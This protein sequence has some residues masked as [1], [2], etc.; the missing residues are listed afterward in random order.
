MEGVRRE[1]AS[2]YMADGSR[3]MAEVSSLLGFSAPSGFSRWYRQQ[4][5]TTASGRGVRSP[6]RAG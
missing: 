3:S 2:R 4:F 5:G 6:R 1:L